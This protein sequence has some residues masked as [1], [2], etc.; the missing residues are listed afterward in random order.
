M[1]YAE[2][3]GWIS[4]KRKRLG[5]A[6]FQKTVINGDIENRYQIN[7]PLDKNLL[8]YRSAMQTAILMLME[9]ENCTEE[10]LYRNII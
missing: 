10:E 5:V 4:I 6:V 3:T 7:I 8:D 1:E 2:N 9:V